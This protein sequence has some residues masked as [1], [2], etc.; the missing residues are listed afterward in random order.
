MKK[1]KLFS[2]T[3][4][5]VFSLI[6]AISVISHALF[7]FMM[8]IVYTNQKETKFRDTQEQIIKVLKNTPPDKMEGIVSR[9]AFQ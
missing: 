5:Y 4:L 7:Y 8:P 3:F 9:Y 2:K 6:A 1:L